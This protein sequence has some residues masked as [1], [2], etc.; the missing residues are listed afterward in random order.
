MLSLYLSTIVRVEQARTRLVDHLRRK[1][2][3]MRDEPDAGYTTEQVVVTALLAA[4]AIIIVGIVVTKI[5]ARANS[6]NLGP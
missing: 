2:Q 6:I 5:T 1:T 4:A 3:Q